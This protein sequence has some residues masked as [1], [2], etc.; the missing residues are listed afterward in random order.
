HA[1]SQSHCNQQV[2]LVH[3][4]NVA[5]ECFISCVEI[6]L[7]GQVCADSIG[8]NIISGVGG[9]MDCKCHFQLHHHLHVRP[10]HHHLYVHI[11]QH[12][13]LVTFISK[14]CSSFESVAELLQF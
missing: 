1:E 9:Q 13:L 8:A 5:D 10:N 12:R 6:D 3:S 7:T 11:N 14:K 4:M 2:I